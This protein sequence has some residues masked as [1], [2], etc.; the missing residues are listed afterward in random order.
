MS[1]KCTKV[2]FKAL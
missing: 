2:I 1:H